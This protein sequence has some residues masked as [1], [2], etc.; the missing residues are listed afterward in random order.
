MLKYWLTHPLLNL[1]DINERLE[2]TEELF[3]NDSLL[4]DLRLL[5]KE[6]MDIERAITFLE[7]HEPKVPFLKKLSESPEELSKADLKKMAYDSDAG[8]IVSQALDIESEINE[9]E[10]SIK[11]YY[12]HSNIIL[13]STSTE[14]NVANCINWRKTRAYSGTTTEQGIYV[15]VKGREPFGI[16]NK[17]VEYEKIREYIINELHNL[18]DYETNNKI[19]FF[20][21]F[22]LVNILIHTQD[23]HVNTEY[24]HWGPLYCKIESHLI[25]PIIHQLSQ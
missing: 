6:I 12:Q 8:S 1:K 18:K 7:K 22:I 15:N 16:I 21:S 3:N 13:Q 5:L 23:V 9:K 25:L 19:E 2:V 20:K 17:G 24:C 11:D 4:A 10:N 14:N